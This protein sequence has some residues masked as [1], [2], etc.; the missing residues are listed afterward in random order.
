[1][2]T[3]RTANAI[4]EDLRGER[5]DIARYEGQQQARRKAGLAH[6][7]LLLALA[8]YTRARIR[9]LERELGETAS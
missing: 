1:M 8:I 2:S 4:R 5:A 9:D 6:D 7:G 3:T